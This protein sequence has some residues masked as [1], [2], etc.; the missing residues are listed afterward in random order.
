M[1]MRT[2]N[3]EAVV[4]EVVRRLNDSG[5]P[6]ALFGGW[7]EEA[8]GLRQP[9]PHA[10]IDL[11]L[12]APSFESLDR[13]LAAAP[14]DL[15]EIPFKRFAHKRAFLLADL[16]VEVVLVQQENGT[17]VTWFWGDVRFEWILP[18]TEDCLL[19]GHRLPAASR[20]NLRHYRALHRSTQPWRWQDRAS[21]VSATVTRNGAW[22]AAR[23]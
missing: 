19:G 21:L 1:V 10:D 8:F 12:P 11:L 6:C 14:S 22:S 18:L 4:V 23:P 20:A 15:S 7:A 16:M 17:A 9:R 2:A 13:L 5:A 3:T